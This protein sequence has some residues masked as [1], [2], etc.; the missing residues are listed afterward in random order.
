VAF[1]GAKRS[2][3]G[4]P[5]TG[6]AVRIRDGIKHAKRTDSKFAVSVAEKV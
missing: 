6:D 1:I 5:A 2:A 3:V 4:E